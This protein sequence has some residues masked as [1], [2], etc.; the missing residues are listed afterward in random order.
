[1][2]EYTCTAISGDRLNSHGLPKLEEKSLKL[3][4]PFCRET[5]K[6]FKN[7]AAGKEVLKA[8]VTQLLL[9]YTRMLELLKRSGPE[10]AALI[11]EA[12]TVPTIMYSIKSLPIQIR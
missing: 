10:C 2:D 6:D 3:H 11:R 9:Y 1:M 7:S 8:A 12:V 5:A 4:T